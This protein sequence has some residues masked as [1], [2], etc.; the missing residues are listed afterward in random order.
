MDAM[1]NNP[2]RVSNLPS[3]PDGPFIFQKKRPDFSHPY[4]NAARLDILRPAHAAR[5]GLADGFSP[6]KSSKRLS[7][8][9]AF[10]LAPAD[11]A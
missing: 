10:I 2:V 9:A 5:R 4:P 1:K 11:G 7:Y 3:N 8:R 6:A